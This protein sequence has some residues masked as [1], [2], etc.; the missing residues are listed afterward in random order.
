MKI[1]DAILFIS[2]E[3]VWQMPFRDRS[4]KLA[5]TEITIVKQK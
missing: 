4:T 1:V 3:L 2:I 5:Q